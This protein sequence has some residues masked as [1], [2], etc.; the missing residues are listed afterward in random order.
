MKNLFLLLFLFRL[1]TLSSAQDKYY[2]NSGNISF[3]GKSTLSKVHANNKTVVSAFNSKTGAIEFTAFIKEFQLANGGM[4][5]HFND[6]YMESD[7]FPKTEFR[8]QVV[9]NAAVKYKTPGVYDVKVTGKLTI[10]GQ[11]KDVETQGKIS[12]MPGKIQLR[13]TFSI[14]V[15]DYKISANMKDKVT[16]DVDCTL[17]PLKL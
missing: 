1:S 17:N 3:D 10:H 8:G 4:Q 2:T 5:R 11:T 6:K 7:L 15:P 16:I 13:S 12:V 9:N 14:Q